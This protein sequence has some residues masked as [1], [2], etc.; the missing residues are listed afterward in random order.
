MIKIGDKFINKRTSKQY[1]FKK[2]KYGGYALLE[3]FNATIW[4]YYDSIKEANTEINDDIK[5]GLLTKVEEENNTNF[6][7]ND[8]KN[9]IINYLNRSDDEALDLLLQDNE[10]DTSGCDTSEFFKVMDCIRELYD[11]C[12][13]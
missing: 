2:Y 7:K 12:S 11:K 3:S 4:D 9:I 10:I 1:E 8:I 13:K 6:T 5:K